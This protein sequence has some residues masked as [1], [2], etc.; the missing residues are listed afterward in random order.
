MKTIIVTGAT[1]GIGYCV[2]RRMLRHNFRVIG[3][4]RDKQRCDEAKRRLFDEFPDAKV[5]YFCADLMHMSGQKKVCDDI[6]EYL[7]GERIFALVN[8]AGCV[9]SWYSTTEEGYEQQFALNHLAGF[10]ITYRLL[11][12]LDEV[13]RIIFSGSN[14]H[15]MT[16]IRW[17]DIMLTRRYNSLFAYKQSK[18]CN[19]LFAYEL[20]RRYE[21]RGI[22][23][24]VVDP[25]LVNTDI[26]NKQT[27]WLVNLVWS[28]RKRKGVSPEVAADTYEYL[29]LGDPEGFYFYDC[30]EAKYSRQVNAQ[31]AARLFE[32]SETL[33]GIKYGD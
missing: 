13:G 8:N 26:G 2:C 18:L 7:D 3:I 17:K 27:G 5:E 14:S 30:L 9:R 25:G 1:S 31:N 11:G 21:K 23:V 6:I 29:C 4:G 28:L 32:L 22:R 33:C 20:K 19:M 24:Y 12:H 15:K 16:K 10:Y